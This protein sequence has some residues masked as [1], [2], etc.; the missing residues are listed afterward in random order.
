MNRLFRPDSVALSVGVNTLAQAAVRG[1]GLV[2][3]W[4]IAWLISAQQ[5]GMFGV[6]MLVLNVLLPLCA[7]GL[8]EGVARYA[9]AHEAA[10][11]LPRFAR[12]A[13]TMALSIAGCVTAIL[14]LAAAPVGRFLFTGAAE[15]S[16][17]VDAVP[18]DE[19]AALM[20][21][22]TVCAFTLALYHLLI[23]FLRGMRM[24]RA[25]SVAEL[26]T[27]VVFTLLAVIG[28]WLGRATA[29]TL[30][31]CYALA[32]I[33]SFVLLGPGLYGAMKSAPSKSPT[34]QPP[35][36]TSRLIRFSLWSA[37]TA[38][39][40][41]AMLLYPMW[42]LLKTTDRETAGFFFGVRIIAHV[43]Q[44]FGV[45]L[46][47][48]VYSHAARSWEHEGPQATMPRLEWLTRASLLGLLIAATALSVCKPILIRLFPAGFVEG[49][50][51]YDPLLT[52]FLLSGVVGLLTIRLNLVEK[53]RLVFWS[54]LVGVAVNIVAAYCL[55]GE[56]GGSSVG[57]TSAA[58]S[59]AAWSGVFGVGAALVVVVAML[60]RN[61]LLPDR[62]TWLIVA[63]A[64]G[65]GLG[66]TIALPVTTVLTLL[67]LSGVL[68]LTPQERN[69]L[70]APVRSLWKGRAG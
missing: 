52:L 35:A 18:L 59:G 17:E 65:P 66:W 54:W 13:A 12:R 56:P 45:L 23:G 7:A 27:A 62:S 14:L 63:A 11:G 50:V 40:W 61:R 8:Y 67:A 24:F 5:L 42:Y 34:E 36:Q 29:A 26:L 48:V 64:I 68:V 30:I 37:G 46:T 22:S 49:A 6:S 31:W 2:R 9:P 44:Y 60:H 3:N 43:V 4:A 53:S 41:H 20:R 32:T 69:R 1:I 55:L 15:M 51:A 25:V 57:S 39:T 58:L 38:I 16:A 21:A 47:M 33:L 10:G 28:A 19:T 70:I